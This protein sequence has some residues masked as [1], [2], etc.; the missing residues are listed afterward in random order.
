MGAFSIWHW[1]IVLTIVAI[2]FGTKRLR[3]LGSDLGSALKGF[4]DSI[5]ESNAENFTFSRPTKVND[6]NINIEARKESP[7]RTFKKNIQEE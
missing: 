2:V 6:Q 1:L 7:T 4:K 5:N 3:N